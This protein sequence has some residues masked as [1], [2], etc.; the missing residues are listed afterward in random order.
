MRYRFEDS[1]LEKLFKFDGPHAYDYAEGIVKKF[2]QRVVSIENAKDERD[3]FAFRSF[4][5]KKLAGDR[6]HQYS[7]RLNDQWRL[8]V[9]LDKAGECTVVG[10]VSIEDYH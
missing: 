3:L 9:E 6:S 1:K 10:I 2:R 7:I 8:I 5:F 4:R